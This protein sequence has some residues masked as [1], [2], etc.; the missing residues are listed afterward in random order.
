[1]QPTTKIGNPPSAP[2]TKY[3]LGS[4]A[5]ATSAMRPTSAK[6][7]HQGERS[8]TANRELGGILN[9]TEVLFVVGVV[10]GW[11]AQALSCNAW[12]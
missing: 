2:T 1:M 9:F 4:R 11:R 8:S 10:G 12:G 3:S 6:L 5:M 7:I